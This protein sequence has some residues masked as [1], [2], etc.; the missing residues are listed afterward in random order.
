MGLTDTGEGKRTIDSWHTRYRILSFFGRAN[1]D[2]DNKYLLSFVLRRDGYSS[3]LGKNRWG[4][5]PGVSA[6]WIFGNESFVKEKLPFLSFGKLR[7]SFGLNGNASGIGAYTLQ[8]SYNGQQYN[9]NMGYLIGTL[10]NPSLRWEK[11]RTFEVGLDL[12]FIENRL[13]TNFTFYD[14]L[15]SDK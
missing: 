7:T 3:L 12:S 4:N 11:T 5:F 13:N 1:Y 9:G 2:Y 10:P 14:R 6:G 15:T 8:G